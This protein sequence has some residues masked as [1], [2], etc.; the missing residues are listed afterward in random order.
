MYTLDPQVK[1][2]PYQEIP[3]ETAATIDM[4]TDPIPECIIHS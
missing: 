4:K 3:H 1:V 2:L